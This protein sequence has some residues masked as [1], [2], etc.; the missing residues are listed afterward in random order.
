MV[1]VEGEVL[2][3]EAQAA[4][5]EIE[6][7]FVAPGAQPLVDAGAVF[8]LAP[9]VLEKV[10]STQTAQ[11]HVAIVRLVP[12]SKRL[13]IEA[14]FAVVAHEV[15]D[16][17]NL[18]TMMRSAEATGADLFVVTAK[19][20]DVTSPKVVRASA[21]SFFRLPVLAVEDFSE[22]VSS[23]RPILATSSH[24]GQ[25]YTEVDLHRSLTLVFGNEAH[26]LDADLPVDEW[27]TIAH[28]GTSESL[29]VA[30]ACTILCFE[31]ARQRRATSG[32]VGER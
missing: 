12:R 14:T 32:T 20:V 28:L 8:T 16:P 19:T 10:A 30:M 13:L 11:P 24:R 21:G 2:I 4:G 27:I 29:N 23:G 25:E 1:V 9:G 15:A 22:V 26:G 7:Q 5:W 17:G 6:S 18:G 3:R 31:V